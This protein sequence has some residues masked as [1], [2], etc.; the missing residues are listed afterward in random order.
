MLGY[1]VVK[2]RAWLS[3]RLRFLKLA[4]CNRDLRKWTLLLSH[5]ALNFIYVYVKCIFVCYNNNTS[6]DTTLIIISAIRESL[7][8]FLLSDRDKISANIIKTKSSGQVMR[9]KKNVN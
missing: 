8:F 9:A 3:S 7:I 5:F 1:S 4:E 2:T 6:N